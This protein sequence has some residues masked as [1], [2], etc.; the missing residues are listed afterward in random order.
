MF[1]RNPHHQFPYHYPYHQNMQPYHYQNQFQ[2]PYQ[3]G[4]YYSPT[5]YPPPNL[6]GQQQ[7]SQAP[8]GEQNQQPPQNPQPGLFTGPDGTFD[9]QKAVSQFDEMM[10]TANQVSPIMKQLGSLFTPKK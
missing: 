7:N 3:Y 8:Q 1:F 5:Y 6:Q 2:H 9:F 10:K 4:P